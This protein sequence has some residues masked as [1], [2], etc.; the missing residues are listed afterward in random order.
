M[1][2]PDLNPDH[3]DPLAKLLVDDE[4]APDFEAAAAEL[5]RYRLQVILGD[6][7]A[8]DPAWQAA[9]LTI[10]NAGSR[11]F[12]GG[13]VV[14][15]DHDPVVQALPRASVRLS[16][17]LRAY[18]A[19]FARSP[20]QFLPS[21]GI[22]VIDPGMVAPVVYPRAGRWSAGVSPQPRPLETESSVL[23]AV[24]AGALAV[25]EVFQRRRGYPVAMERDVRV[26]LWEPGGGPV[27]EGP[28]ITE[29]PSELW[30]LGLGHLG[31]AYA[32]L[33]GLLPYP[34][35][36]E[37]PLYLQDTD[38]LGVANRATAMLHTGRGIGERKTRNVV[39]ILEP[40]GWDTSIVERRY[41]GGRLRGAGEPA[42][43]LGGVDNNRTRRAFDDAGF[44]AIY[45]AGLGAGADSYLDMTIRRLPGSR[46]S[47]EL[48]PDP[49]EAAGARRAA[50]YDRLE[51]E[52]GDQCGVELLAGRAVGTAFVGVVAACWGIGGVLREIHGGRRIELVRYSLRDPAEVIAIA[53]EASG[54]T[55]RVPTCPVIR[56]APSRGR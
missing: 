43:L 39:R 38:R 4:A 56:E 19:S 23:A 29:L 54:G 8:A 9:L 5:S 24:F 49:P 33:L 42:L 50:A 10:V 27:S 44:E 52:T 36:G 1:S 55:I 32:W 40:L 51:Q 6:D 22:G 20:D 45:D 46:P 47:I 3:L 14:V 53:D 15:M 26:S 31:Q 16:K 17:A 11:A 41:E 7:A 13:V 18:G 37:R 12:H 28:P 48:Y 2:V 30:L 35:Q 34:R 25:S 21:I